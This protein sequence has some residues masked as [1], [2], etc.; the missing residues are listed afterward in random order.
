MKSEYHSKS[1]AYPRA[2]VAGAVLAVAVATLPVTAFAEASYEAF[3][4]ASLGLLPLDDPPEGFS[5]VDLNEPDTDAT[6]NAVA[7]IVENTAAPVDE[8]SSF[9]LQNLGVSGSAGP[10]LAG[11]SSSDASVKTS[12]S[13]T[14]L[15]NGTDDTVS[16]NWGFDYDLYVSASTSS[17]F[18]DAGAKASLTLGAY[19][20]SDTAFEELI[21]LPL[22][23]L[24]LDGPGELF[25]V[26]YIF[27]SI[28]VQ[29]GNILSFYVDLDV[30]GNASSTQ[31]VPVPAALVLFCS[32]FAG[33]LGMG[34]RRRTAGRLNA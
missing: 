18:D 26:D 20:E 15:P 34:L 19:I 10:S 12:M 17:V 14:L 16:I 7:T 33:L 5:S 24:K 22:T 32:G 29:P 11:D 2:I 21:L 3:G 28:D 8:V 27:G 1:A 13:L 23:E 6:G 25:K 4:F 9:T 30:V 31:V